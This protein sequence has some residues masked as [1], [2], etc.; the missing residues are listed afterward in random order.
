MNAASMAVGG[1]PSA[2]GLEQ[3]LA[4][5]ESDPET[6]RRLRR[7]AREHPELLFAVAA[8]YLQ[9]ECVPPLAESGI[10]R[11]LVA[12]L[13][14]QDSFF[15]WL[16]NPG[17]CP[18]N[19][20]LHLFKCVLAVDPTLDFKLARMLPG[21]EHSIR[22]RV[23]NAGQAARAIDILEQ[24]SSDQ[25]LLPVIKHLPGSADARVAAKAALFVGRRV[26]DP[27]WVRKQMG[28]Q[29][30]RLRANAVEATWGATSD[31]AVRLL[32]NCISDENN[33]VAG[34]ALIGLHK[35][36]YHG[37][38]EHALAM[39]ASA[40]PGRRSSAAWAMG[41]IA[42]PA[43]VDR[44][45]ALLRDEHPQVRSTA[46]RSLV[47]LG[48]EQR[49]ADSYAAEAEKAEAEKTTA[50]QF[51]QPETV[52]AEPVVEEPRPAAGEREA[53]EITQVPFEINLDGSAK[54]QRRK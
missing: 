34:N 43:F 31:D 48:Q 5:F 30:G 46:I 41:K 39:A 51:A 25:R 26:N 4:C 17:R 21:R 3:E 6:A 7:Y 9:A 44:L 23:L 24:T 37:V 50:L 38:V 13:V 29:D 27:A 45:T 52:A 35:A 42:G 11:F 18:F 54:W 8:K 49:R 2:A 10:R 15:E 47:T 14:R 33:R 19:S 36:G 1:D 32:K 20:A 40:E 28:H 22:H 12:L 53:V 16:V